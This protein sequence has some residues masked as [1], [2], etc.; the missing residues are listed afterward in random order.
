[1]GTKGILF[2]ILFTI[3]AV[4]LS[5]CNEEFYDVE[6]EEKSLVSIKDAYSR[7]LYDDAIDRSRQFKARYP[8]AHSSIDIDLVIADSYYQMGEYLESS[9]HYTR[10]TQLYPKHDKKPYAMYQIGMAHWQEA[11]SA[12]DREQASTE[13]ALKEWRK[14]VKLHPKSSYAKKASHSIAEGEDRILESMLLKAEFYANKALW[15]SCATWALEIISNSSEK[16]N[17]K[18]EALK[19]GGKAF[20]HLSEE[21]AKLERKKDMESLQKNIYFKKFTVKELQEKSLDLQA[22]AKNL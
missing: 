7:G 20:K 16:N 14:L 22:K 13:K 2:C 8:Y 21:K 12:P 19:L 15:H 6:Q 17:Y 4:S 9:I 3:I 11:P 5:G 10:F 18:K 1:M